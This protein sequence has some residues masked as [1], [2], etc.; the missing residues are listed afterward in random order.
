MRARLTRLGTWEWK[1]KESISSATSST[2]CSDELSICG[3]IFDF[4]GKA[5]RLTEVTRDL[6]DPKIWDDQ[7]RAQAQLQATPY[8]RQQLQRRG[9]GNNTLADAVREC[10]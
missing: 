5:A 9:Y 1:Q 4:D 3:G 6:E 8:Y 7:E 10:Y 2:I